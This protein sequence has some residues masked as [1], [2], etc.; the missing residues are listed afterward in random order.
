MPPCFDSARRRLRSDSCADFS[1]PAAPLPPS[2]LGTGLPIGCRIVLRARAVEAAALSAAAAAVA[3]ARA[4][5]LAASRTSD[6]APFGAA[7]FAACSAAA[8]F[9]FGRLAAHRL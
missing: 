6:A 7:D 4:S 3:A 5:T 1:P 9:P 2:P 8:A